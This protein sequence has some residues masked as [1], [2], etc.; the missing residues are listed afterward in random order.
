[1]KG[2]KGILQKE[3][4]RVFSDKK[5][6]VSLYVLPLILIIAMY[7]FMG[8]MQS[9]MVED[10][11][12]H[13]ATVYIQNQPEGFQDIIKNAKFTADVKYLEKEDSTDTIKNDIKEGATD[14]LVVF[15]DG[16]LD[17]IQGYKEGNPIPE[18]K[19]YYNPLEDYS[20][21]ARSNFVEA[22]LSNYKQQ[23]LTERIGSLENILVFNIDMDEKS[24]QIMNEEKAAGKTFGTI[25]PY[26]I[27]FMLF[28][29]VMGLAI[30]A[31]TGEKERGTMASML[32]TPLKRGEIVCGK[33]LSL[34]IL[35]SL[36]AAVYAIGMIVAM[37]MMLKD[38]VGEEAMGAMKL[39]FTPLQM[40]Q[41][42]VI[43]LVLVFFYVT[44]V[45][46]IAVISRTAKEANTYVTPIYIIV[47][48]AGMI[49]MFTGGSSQ[50]AF[51][52]IPVYGS[53]IAI[54]DLLVG[55]LSMAKFGANIGGT[56]LL[57][58]ILA[59]LITKAFNSEKVMFNA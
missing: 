48:V 16:F 26:L 14:L 23:L 1:M 30:D 57:T 3:L 10:I 52:G 42:L 33:I 4:A 37:P 32:L 7:S 53:A 41:L 12:K 11:E 31:I 38:M 47:L 45:S 29:G 6:V 25:L 18:V 50:V 49:T 15:E 46:L 28:A 35:S 39:S 17:Q 21:S 5:L 51:Y 34:V 20:I 55:E 40:I 13:K 2:I 58:V 27:T 36:S 9:N 8:K 43:M 44:V 54:K 24:S 19:T 22:I 56:I 59:V